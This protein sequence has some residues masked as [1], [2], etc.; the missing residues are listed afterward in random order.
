MSGTDNGGG[1]YNGCGLYFWNDATQYSQSFVSCSATQGGRY[2]SNY[3]TL[4][5]Q[6]YY[7]SKQSGSF[8][9]DHP[10]PEKNGYMT[11]QHKFVESPTE[12]DNLYRYEVCTQNCTASI[13]LPDYFKFLNKNVQFL[14]SPKNH[15][16]RGYACINEDYTCVNFTSNCEGAYNILVMG[17]RK[18]EFAAAAWKGVETLKPQNDAI[19]GYRVN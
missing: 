6:F 12:G 8:M 14:I 7:I 11:L 2:L 15:F 10:D 5:T 17:T 1:F 18:D 3:S 13:E 9:I 4:Y 19:M 16:G